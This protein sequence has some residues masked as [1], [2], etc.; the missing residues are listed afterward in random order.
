MVSS[1]I[2]LHSNFF[3]E[4]YH[5]EELICTESVS[6]GKIQFVFNAINKIYMNA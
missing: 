6:C 2:Q 5:R 1:N 4:H 3:C